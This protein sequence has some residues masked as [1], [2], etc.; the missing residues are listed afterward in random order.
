MSL[1]PLTFF[2]FAALGLA[3][4][5]VGGL[6]G[7]VLGVLRFPLILATAESSI[8]VTAGTNIGISTCGAIAGAIRHL[9]QNNVHFRIFAIMATTGAGGAFIGAFLT[10]YFPLNLLLMVR[11]R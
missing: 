7:L 11:V 2:M 10:K 4:G 6:V 5:F 1:D 3:I 8:A 9:R